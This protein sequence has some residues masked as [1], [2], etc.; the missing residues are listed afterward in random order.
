[1][2]ESCPNQGKIIKG[3]GGLYTILTDGG[4]E[5]L[6]KPRGI[7]RKDMISPFPGDNVIFIESF[8]PDVPFNITEILPR[9]NIMP[10][11]VVA[12][13]DKLLIFAS[14]DSP[15]PDFQFIDKMIILSIKLDIEPSLAIT[16]TDLN[17]E[18]A[19]ELMRVY[20]KS[21]ISVLLSG[22]E[23][24]EHKI[25]DK[26]LLKGGTTAFA[27]LSGTGKSTFFNTIIDFEHMETGEVGHKSN[28]GRHTTRH[29]E[30]MPFHGGFIVDT[31]G[32]SSI[33]LIDL[34]VDGDDVEAGYP[35]IMAVKD[36][37]RFSGCRH[38]GDLGCAVNET[39][40]D[41]DR[42]E[43]YRLFRETVDSIPDYLRK[44]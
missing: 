13:I 9:K 20:E 32:F 17:H 12:N 11:P 35:E 22:M 19:N 31:P 2:A 41:R 10:R 3:V 36:N 14:V 5:V 30:L 15:P 6:A 34:G 39:D 25:D 28:R 42:L 40:I 4:E 8:D 44:S 23:N 29:S 24:G 27:G 43:R 38:M 33:E 1:M 37:C 18:M 26:S 21:G 7:F 16:K